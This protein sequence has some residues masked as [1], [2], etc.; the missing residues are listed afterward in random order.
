MR[1]QPTRIDWDEAFAFYCNLDK[2]Q[3]TY[4]AVAEAFPISEQS[5][6]VR[7]RTEDWPAA[8]AEIDRQAA[9]AAMRKVVKSRS[10]RVAATL[11]FADDYV[12]AAAK[13]LKDGTLDI[14]ASDVPALVKTAELLLGE[15]TDRVQISQIRPL[16]DA[17]DAAIEQLRDITGDDEAADRIVAK[18][19][20]EL[21]AV[22]ATARRTAT[23]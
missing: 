3:R 15:P 4:R 19:D 7:G 22:A 2:T 16:L 6:K 5:V 18:L 10:E 1:N 23:A 14:K 17:Y 20:E 9:E 11:K 8:A 13:N 21:L 12:D